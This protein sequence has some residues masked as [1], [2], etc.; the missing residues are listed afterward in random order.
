MDTYDLFVSYSRRDNAQGRVTA[1]VG[2]ISRDFES[3]AGRPLRPLFDVSEIGGMDDWRHRILRG[4]RES[5]LLIAILS[6]TYLKSPYCEWE[7]ND[8]VNHEISR[9]LVGDG[10]APIYF[11]EVDWKEKRSE[12]QIAKWVEELR[13]RNYFDLQPWFHQGEEALRDQAVQERMTDLAKRIQKRIRQGQ[14]SENAKGNVDKFNIYFAGRTTEMRLLRESTAL[15]QVGVLTAVQGL[16]GIGKTAL[17]CAYAHTYAS[18]YPG[19]RWQVKCEGRGDLRAALISLAGVRDFEFEFRDEEKRDPDLGF[20]RVLRELKKRADATSDPKRVLLILDNVD[21]PELL[22][23][24]QTQ[25][26]PAAD[27]LH[28]IATT[29]LG[30]ADLGRGPDRCYVA[31]NE[32]PEKDAVALIQKWQPG[33]S[34]PNE[35][36]RQAAHGLARLLG[37]FTLAIEAAAVL[38]RPICRRGDLRRVQIAAG[39]GRSGRIGRGG[40]RSCHPC[41]A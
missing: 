21:K 41:P 16:G 9:G 2:K 34:F 33:D 8:Y 10:I 37:G 25:R 7:F 35:E 26:L 23:P 1:L 22:A 36:E 38:P 3:F 5:R 17:A 13:R 11:V 14:L 4:L 15:K 31:I 39:E 12:Q 24:A 18:E 19:G 27:W 28:V 20:E 29:R 30:E 6:P 40:Q 32:L